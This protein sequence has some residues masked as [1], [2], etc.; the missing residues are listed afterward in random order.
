MC[1]SEQTNK[2]SDKKHDKKKLGRPRRT[3][4]AKRPETKERI[5]RIR[6]EPGECQ[7]ETAR[8]K[9]FARE[10]RPAQG[11]GH[12]FSGGTPTGQLKYP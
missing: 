6:D 8:I 12:H 2:K 9:E 7:E 11:V 3:K 10:A 4:F 5:R 1:V